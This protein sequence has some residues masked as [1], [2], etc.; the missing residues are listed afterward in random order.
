MVK[1]K[2]FNVFP[3]VYQDTDDEGRAIAPPDVFYEVSNGW[4]SFSINDEFEANKLSRYLNKLNEEVLFLRNDEILTNQKELTDL[5]Y[6]TV[7]DKIDNLIRE[8]NR[9][10]M[11]SVHSR[12]NISRNYAITVLKELKKDFER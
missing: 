9:T 5:I 6:K 1:I 10:N 7:C 8:L 3:D 4:I 2:G 12:I 11:V